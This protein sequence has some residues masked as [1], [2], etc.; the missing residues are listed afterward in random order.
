MGLDASNFSRETE[1]FLQISAQVVSESGA[2]DLEGQRRVQEIASGQLTGTSMKDIEAMGSGRDVAMSNLGA[3]GTQFEKALEFSKMRTNPIL[4]KLS[5]EDRTYLAD[6]SPDQIAAGSPILDTIAKEQGITPDQLRESLIGKGG[7]KEFRSTIGAKEAKAHETSQDLMG[8]YGKNIS[9]QMF[10]EKLKNLPADAAGREDIEAD[11]DAAASAQKTLAV[12]QYARGAGGGTDWRKLM[13]TVA[14]KE[15][16]TTKGVEGDEAPKQ[17]EGLAVAGDKSEAKSQQLSLELF[18]PF[19]DAYTQ[20]SKDVLHYSSDFV[21]AL[22]TMTA[23]LKGQDKPKGFFEEYFPNI[24]K[25]RDL[26]SGKDFMDNLG[27][28]A[29]KPK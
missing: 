9:P 18:K 22:I 24:S 8:K 28:S 25:N 13:S 5:E 14:A 19:S 3:G 12:S 20:A 6:L 10:E 23:A 27:K 2:R 15:G 1:K 21:S 11:R 17:V 16:F 7:S 4:S 29:L 26:T